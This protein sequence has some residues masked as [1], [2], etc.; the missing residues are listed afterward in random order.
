MTY[1][2]AVILRPL[3]GVVCLLSLPLL[4]V[5]E[6]IGNLTYWATPGIQDGYAGT[7]SAI[8]A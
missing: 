4:S 1:R 8:G 5:G 3:I 2:R 7:E 6:T